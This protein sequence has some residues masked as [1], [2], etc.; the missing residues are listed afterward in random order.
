[1]KRV[2]I[3][4]APD[5]GYLDYGYAKRFVESFLKF[6]PYELTYYYDEIAPQP[7]D[8]LII[9]HL[10]HDCLTKLWQAS[11]FL[12][13]LKGNFDGPHYNYRYN[14]VGFAHKVFAQYLETYRHF[15]RSVPVQL[16]WM[17]SDIEVM[18]PIADSMFARME[19][20]DICYLGR[21][22]WHSC[23]SLIS[24][25]LNPSTL[26]FI[27]TLTGLYITGQALTYPE[28]TD[29]YLFD[30][31]LDD[32]GRDNLNLQILN[33]GRG[34]DGVGPYNVFDNV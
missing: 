12:P 15:D 14:L 27:D 33:L 3:T 32:C 28:W 9:R 22:S 13:I 2:F 29:A 30:R 20:Y 1:M 21:T 19:A 10:R 31:V 17:D 4:T 34:I 11:R 25:V 5:S 16:V 26:K 8:R 23:T 18:G 6:T 24:Y 7:T